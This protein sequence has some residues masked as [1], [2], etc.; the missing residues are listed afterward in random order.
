[1]KKSK[2]LPTIVLGCICL[3]VALLLS[4][5]NS[6]TGP[7]IEAAQNA[8]ANE[9]LL[10]VLP[11]AKGFEE[12]TIDETFPSA[13]KAGYKADNGYV[14]QASVTGKSSGLVLMFGINAEGKIVGTKVIAEQETDSY[15]AKVFPDVEGLTGK[16]TGMGLDD[17]APYLVAGATLT[18]SAYGDA[19]KA[20]LQA[21]AIA[22]GADVDIRTPEQI[23]QDNCNAALGTTGVTF[24]K[25]FATEVLEGIDAVYEAADQSGRVF[26]LGETFIGVK[27][28]GT[29]LDAGTV[30]ASLITA[31][32]EAIVGSS[33]T[34]ITERPEGIDAHVTK[35]Y[36]TASG[37][38][39]FEAK[40]EGFSVYQY[41]E[42]SSGKNEP[43]LFKV[44]IAAD[45]KIIDCLTLSSQESQGYGDKCH[46]EEYLN[47]WTGVTAD[48][49]IISSSP[50][51]G[52]CTDPGAIAGATY[53]AQG[54][55]KAMKAVF[56]AFELLNAQGGE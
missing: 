51:T 38:F 11:D 6:I 30:D 14:F 53:T 36:K 8:A 21:F 23:L 4:L 28:D 26:V 1:M 42:Y 3:V 16:Y 48:R 40:A 52:D 32:H 34:E 25:W 50:I 45:G 39:V 41:E 24:T 5:V 55:Q 9:A 20:A 7:I 44:S 33:M 43:I 27:A 47:S 2:F 56:A 22:G 31:A 46:T 12:I 10:E 29:I 18:S 35:I 13:I 17:F 15:D 37:N 19:A 54:Y 49:V